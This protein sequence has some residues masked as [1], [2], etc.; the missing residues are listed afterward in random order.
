M[1][2]FNKKKQFIPF[3]KLFQVVTPKDFVTIFDS[4]LAQT[5]AFILSFSPKKSY[6]KKVIYLL[7]TLESHENNLMRRSSFIIRE[8]LNQ[9]QEDP[10]SLTFVQAVEKEVEDMI[11]GYENFNDLRNLRKRLYF[12]HP[13][14]IQTTQNEEKQT[15]ETKKQD[16]KFLSNW[17]YCD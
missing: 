15:L 16:F 14:E 13:K 9:C 2:K 17:P 4:E 8:Y 5:L 7:D 10:F 12:K 1:F 11:S 3:E 6:V